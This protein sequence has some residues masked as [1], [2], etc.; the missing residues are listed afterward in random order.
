MA[1]LW[2]SVATWWLHFAAAGSVLLLLGLLLMRVV[3][4]PARRQQLG[5]W[6]V[7]AALIVVLLSLLPGW[8]PLPWSA[9]PAVGERAAAAPR[10]PSRVLP[11][12]PE[13]L[14]QLAGRDA[15]PA[16][17]DQLDLAPPA[18]AVPVERRAARTGIPLYPS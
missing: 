2:T 10:L 12:P 3:R 7:V 16:P 15:P 14:R 17:L 6:A 18:A 5:T 13:D 4:Q 9:E 8:L 1:E 11:L